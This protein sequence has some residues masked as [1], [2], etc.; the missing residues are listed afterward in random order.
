MSLNDRA[1]LGDAFSRQPAE[2]SDRGDTILKPNAN[3]THL[4]IFCTVHPSQ[5]TH[6]S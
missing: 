2:R 4:I 1:A 5:A 3:T 6:T